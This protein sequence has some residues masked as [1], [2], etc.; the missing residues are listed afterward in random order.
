MREARAGCFPLADLLL[1]AADVRSLRKRTR[2]C[3]RCSLSRP[4]PIA[5]RATTQTRYCVKYRAKEPKLVLKVTDDVRCLKY[6][7][8]QYADVKKV[9]KLNSWYFTQCTRVQEQ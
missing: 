7:T 8:D 1:Q 6:Q 4:P 5:P 9:E 3:R 2:L